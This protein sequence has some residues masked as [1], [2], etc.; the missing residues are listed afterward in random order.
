MQRNLTWAA[1]L[2]LSLIMSGYSQADIV[3]DFTTDTNDVANPVTTGDLLDLDS[4][5]IALGDLPVT[6]D[7]VEDTTEGL[8]LTLVS[9][10]SFDVAN[11]TIN[12]VSG[13]FGLN[14]PTPDGGSE[15][16]SRF[17]VDAVEQLQISF[18]L[19]VFIEAADFSSL[20]GDE[21]FTVGSET[22]INNDTVDGSNIFDFTA[23]GTTPGQLLAA[24]TP[25]L[26]EATGP[27]GASVGLI[28]LEVAVVAVPE[29]NSLLGLMGLAGLFAAKRRR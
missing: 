12:G 28:S 9:A 13:S 16:P 25:L 19:D 11:T 26:L 10:S 1:A 15:N 22:G 4:P 18:N 3:I 5:D 14:S 21:G 20:T 24:G 23:G 7:V 17:D 2:I 27:A 8:T 29:P 6:V